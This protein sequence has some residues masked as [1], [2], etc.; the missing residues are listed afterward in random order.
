MI[1]SI[2]GLRAV[3]VADI[4][5]KDGN[6]IV[7]AYKGEPGYIEDGT[8]G[9][10]WVEHSLFFYKHTYTEDA[11]EVV[12]SATQLA[13]F[14]PA[15]IF[16]NTDGTLRQKAY[17]AAYPLAIVN[18][19]ATSRA[20]VFSDVYSLNTAITAARTLGNNYTV[21]T[22]AEWYTECLYMWV[23]FATRNLQAIM[24]GASDMPY[25]SNRHSN[26]S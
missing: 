13:G 25:I 3:V 21:T 6:F 2:H 18:G 12:I 26:G 7:N 16:V 17:T 5:I 11:E 20:N 8:N 9:E 22:I 24:K 23:E 19:Q 15:P 1:I 4:L 14:Q 10:V